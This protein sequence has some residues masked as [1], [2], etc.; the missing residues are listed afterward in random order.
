MAPEQRERI[1]SG[2]PGP[3]GFSGIPGGIAEPVDGG[4]RLKGRWQF[5]TGCQDAPWATLFG[6][7]FDGGVPRTVGGAPELRAFIVP[8]GDFAIERTWDTATA[9]RGTGSHAVVVPEAFVPEEYS[10][11]SLAPP[12][13]YLESKASHWPFATVGAGGNAPIAIG[14]A[15]RVV[16]E[17]I[18]SIR[19]QSPRA[20]YTPYR[21]RSEIQVS[22]SNARSAVA[23][24]SASFQ[25][26]ARE[27]DEAS[28]QQ[29]LTNDLR[30]EMWGMF[31]YALDQCRSVVTDMARV[32]G[33]ALYSTENAVEMGVRDLNAICASMESM[34]EIQWS[35]GKVLFGMPPGQPPYF[36]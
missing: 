36:A 3:F 17:V 16:E 11:S 32:A 14:I 12:K 19:E 30:A 5:L 28:A 18:K 1:F 22:V 25:A 31:F 34:R 35:A 24:L 20:E 9:M 8:A 27:I 2:P 29:R 13:R 26:L 7:V 21:D 15:R 23:S 4:Y 6:K 10:L 33:S